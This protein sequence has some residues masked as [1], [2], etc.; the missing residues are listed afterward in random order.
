M[1]RWIERKNTP[2]GPRYREWVS[3]VDKYN[4]PE[5]TREEMLEHLHW[6]EDRE[7][8]LERTDIQ[9]TSIL[10]GSHKSRD[11]LSDWTLERC[12][13]CGVFHHPFKTINPQGT[14]QGCGEKEDDR[15]HRQP[16]PERFP[17]I[18]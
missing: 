8:R 10:E 7:A 12:D 9:G 5:L 3:V 11:M 14:C 4:T 15:S 18:V 1:A 16:C 2:N 13:Y 17:R 6:Y